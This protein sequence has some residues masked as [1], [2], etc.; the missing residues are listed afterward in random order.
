[1]KKTMS[2][3]IAL[4][5]MFTMA[6]SAMAASGTYDNSGSITIGNAIVGQT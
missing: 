6:A 5:L 3:L 1:M 4:L 2:V